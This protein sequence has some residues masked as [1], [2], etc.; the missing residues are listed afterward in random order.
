LE[1]NWPVNP[2]ANFKIFKKECDMKKS[3]EHRARLAINK[4]FL[5][6]KILAVAFLGMFGRV[7]AVNGQG[8]QP[9]VAIHD[10]ELTRALESMPAPAQRPR[11]RDTTSNQ[12]W[13]TQWHYFVMPDA[14]KEAL[15]SDGTAFTVMGDSNILA[16]V[17]TNADGSPKYPIVISLGSEAI[18]RTVR[19]PS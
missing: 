4:S 9:I 8:A 12:W 10:S 6:M 5:L 18:D 13:I 3:S 2:P 19:L 11:D 14:V 17:L 16:G 15:R 7:C 1:W